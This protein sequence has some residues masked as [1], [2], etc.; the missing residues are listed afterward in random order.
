LV[1]EGYDFDPVQLLY[2]ACCWL[3]KLKGL[4][5]S[6]EI[7]GFTAALTMLRCRRVVGALWAV[8]DASSVEFARHWV[9]S[10]LTHAFT[11]GT[12]RS[13]HAFAFAIKKAV[14]RLR[15]AENGKFAHPFFW[16]AYTL[17]GLG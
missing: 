3:G 2:N 6:Q 5:R 16:A 1:A 10:L 13:P 15:T 14:N 7:E 17:M 11:N 4:E 12:P 9:S 8:P